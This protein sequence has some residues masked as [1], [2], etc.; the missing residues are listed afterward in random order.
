VY[1]NLGA[2]LRWRLTWY[3]KK[4]SQQEKETGNPKEIRTQ[5]GR[6]EAKPAELTQLCINYYT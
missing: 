1:F 3:R 4:T 5:G 2:I 6:S